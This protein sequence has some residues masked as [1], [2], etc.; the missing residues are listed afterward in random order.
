MRHSVGGPARRQCP[1]LVPVLRDRLPTEAAGNPLALVELP[2]S[3]RIGPAT[4]ELIRREAWW[5]PARDEHPP[6][7]LPGSPLR[8]GAR[9][10]LPS[11]QSQVPDNEHARSQGQW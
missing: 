2:K 10:S 6:G 1:R 3:V 5:P 9:L 7:N 11:S 8:H 4:K